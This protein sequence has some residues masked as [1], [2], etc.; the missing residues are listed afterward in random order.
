MTRTVDQAA[1]QTAANDLDTTLFVEAAAGTGK[2]T[3]LVARILTAVTTGRARLH[4]IVAITFTEKAAGELKIRLREELERKLTGEKLRA[5]LADLERAQITTI[6]S[7]CAALLRERPVEAGVDPQFRVA[8]ALQRDLLLDEAWADWLATEL[9]NN[10]PALRQALF[11][12]VRIEQLQELATLLVNARVGAISNR[13][14]SRLQTA[15]TEGGWPAAKPI[16]IRAQWQKLLDQVPALERCLKHCVAPGERFAQNARTFCDTVPQLAGASAERLVAVLNALELTGPRKMAD[17]DSATAFREFKALV[18]DLK[19]ALEE[20]AA[21]T[22]HN[23]LVDLTT[24]LTGFVGAFQSHKRAQAVL[25]FDDLL[26]KARGLLW[27]KAVRDELSGRI[28]FLLVDEFQDTDPVQAEIVLALGGDV[29]GKLF[30]VGDPKQS[31]YGFRR[32]D[33][34]MYAGI[35]H[36]L[37]KTGRVLQFQQNFRSQ[38]T[39]LDWVNAVFSRLIEKPGYVP[40]AASHP[41]TAKVT[42]LKPVALPEKISMAETRRLE[43][44]AIAQHL[45]GMVA[46]KEAK[47][48]DVALLFRSFT[49][50]ATYAEVFLEQGV[51]YRVI[52]GR[53]Y[54]Q[55]QEIQTLVSLLCC[56]DNP[57]D[58]LNLVAVLRSVLFGWTDEQVLRAAEADQLDYLA[59]VGRAGWPQPAASEPR[60]GALG[61]RALPTTTEIA[62]DLLR[63]LH[64]VRHTLSVPAFVERV[65]ARTHFCQ[66]FAASG[67][68]GPA[69]VANLLK[70]LELARQLEAAGVHSL[71]GFVRQLRRTVVGGVDEEPAPANE[72]GEDVVQL[73]T[74]HKAKGLEFPVVVLADL[75]GQ[76]SD[77]GAQLLGRELRFAGGKTAGFAAAKEEQNQ[78]DEAEEIRLLY[79]AATRAKQRLVVP[80]FAKKG[81]RLD[82]LLRGMGDAT[83]FSEEVFGVR[84]LAGALGENGK[85]PTSRRTPKERQAWREELAAL[86]ARAAA[87]MLRVSPSKLGGEAE[88]SEEDNQR[89]PALELGVLVHEALERG[90]ASGLTGKAKEMVECALRSALM[91][92]VA[93][94]AEVHRELPFVVDGM[95]GKIDLLFREGPRWTLVDYKTDARAEPEK[96]RAQMTAY[97]DAL[98]RVA[99]VEVAEVLL[100]FVATNEVLPVTI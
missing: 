42:L 29:P 54:Y 94:A 65:L 97:C 74:M 10:P 96:Y 50:V 84:Q 51:P 31:I 15:P 64:A 2:T 22:D 18:K 36:K 80:V 56:L 6:H 85:A 37:A 89:R 68:D 60:D 81:E 87:T 41:A 59:V 58:K 79:V 26:E 73:L 46:G 35:R 14:R 93:Q 44:T 71:R 17:C 16:N 76:S 8:D 19:T 66:A 43:A 69:S 61:E 77:S 72:D 91:Q 21:A 99:G 38:A 98:R 32:A 88:P 90:D 47:W 13:D 75:A 34:E 82:L 92:R 24:W 48:G 5:A 12:E 9:A 86:V 23:F 40:L 4:E 78:R 1:R 7:F 39:I 63:E 33:I 3:T 25:D 83:R 11:R 52:G 20:F 30:I 57:N 62:F 45:Q 95:E 70:A 67:P 28:K 53:G 55:R 100:F 49:G 27:N